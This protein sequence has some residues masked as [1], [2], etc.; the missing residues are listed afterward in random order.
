M[1]VILHFIVVMVPHSHLRSLFP[2]IFLSFSS[3]TVLFC[4]CCPQVFAKS[5][6]DILNRTLRV[7]VPYKGSHLK[8]SYHSGCSFTLSHYAVHVMHTCRVY[9]K[10]LI[11]VTGPIKLWQS[12]WN[13]S[14]FHSVFFNKYYRQLR[15]CT[16]FSRTSREWN[17]YSK[18]V[19]SIIVVVAMNRSNMLGFGWMFKHMYRC[20]VCLCVR[21]CTDYSK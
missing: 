2:W 17:Y 15:E 18:K 7:T 1:P 9:M 19:T 16:L 20:S 6:T 14:N 5:G 21:L 13:S 4:F 12:I 10:T 11:W 3:S 8:W